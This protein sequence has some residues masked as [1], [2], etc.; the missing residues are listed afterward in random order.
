MYT[1]HYTSDIVR[2]NKNFGTNEIH[3]NMSKNS[4]ISFVS[5]LD[6]EYGNHNTVAGMG[7][8]QHRLDIHT[9]SIF[10]NGRLVKYK[11]VINEQ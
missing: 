2:N 5:E 4:V 10:K 3:E 11:E 9:V 6:T 8:W 1:I 7:I